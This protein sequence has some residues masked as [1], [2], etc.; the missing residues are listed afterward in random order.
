MGLWPRTSDE[1]FLTVKISHS[2]IALALAPDR[3]IVLIVALGGITP[4]TKTV[5]RS[6]GVVARTM[7]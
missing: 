7:P 6:K 3:Q 2:V 1:V 4:A 5:R